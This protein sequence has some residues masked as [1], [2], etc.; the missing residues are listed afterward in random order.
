MNRSDF[1]VTIRD[2]L[3]RDDLSEALVGSFITMALNQLS[4]SLRVDRMIRVSEALLNA[5]RIRLPEDWQEADFI[6]VVDSHV[7]TYLSRDEYYNMTDQ[8]SL[9][10]YTLSG[11]YLI[12][13]GE[14]YNEPFTNV[15]LSYFADILEFTDTPGPLDNW[16][17]L[18]HLHLITMCTL[19]YAS[20]YGIED[21]RAA[22]FAGAAQSMI[23]E[24]NAAYLKSKTS[25]SRMNKVMGKRGFG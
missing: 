14:P 7:L 2:W 15:E 19:S 24:L 11:R 10:H 8:Q 1:I 12:I 22:V 5:N 17:L 23:D 6:R 21:E 4:S 25:G 18:H 9:K 13:G 20:G 16:L 3:N